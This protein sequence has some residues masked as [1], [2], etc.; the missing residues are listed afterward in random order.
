MEQNLEKRL[1]TVEQIFKKKKQSSYHHSDSKIK[2]Y[3]QNFTIEHKNTIETV[4]NVRQ[5]CNMHAKTNSTN[6]VDSINNSFQDRQ[7]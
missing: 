1:K 5:S 7:T 3:Q 6:N 4:R 2:K